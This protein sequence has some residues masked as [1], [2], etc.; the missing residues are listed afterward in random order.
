M[1]SKRTMTI[2]TQTP[3]WQAPPTLAELRKL[4]ECKGAIIGAN[5]H[6]HEYDIETPSW[7]LNIQAEN[8]DYVGLRRMVSILLSALPDAIQANKKLSPQSERYHRTK[9]RKQINAKIAS[10]GRS[11]S[12]TCSIGW[13]WCECATAKEIKA[14]EALLPGLIAQERAR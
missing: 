9:E 10:L 11:H 8:G 14:L 7:R 2:Q 12:R 5:P 6:G 13:H 1:A 4:A 3:G